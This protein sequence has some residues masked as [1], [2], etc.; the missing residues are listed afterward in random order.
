MNTWMPAAAVMESRR[1]TLRNPP[2]LL[3]LVGSYQPVPAENMRFDLFQQIGEL[4]TGAY[5]RLQIH[6]Q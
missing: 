1:V 5:L 6:R 4:Q 2:D 3:A